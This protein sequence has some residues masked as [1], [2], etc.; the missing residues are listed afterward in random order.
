MFLRSSPLR[1]PKGWCRQIALTVLLALQGAIA[2]SSLLEPTEKGRL[3]AHA[4]QQGAVHQ[5]QHDESTCAV[6][7]V[8]SLHASPAQSCAPVV[9]ERQH[10]VAALDAPLVAAIRVDPTTLPRAPP[11]LS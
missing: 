1:R 11:Q 10:S 4:E 5:Y 6:C 9:C 3:G 2:F 7:S 8:R